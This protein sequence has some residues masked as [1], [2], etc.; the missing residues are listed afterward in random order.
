MF[1]NLQR[2]ERLDRKGERDLKRCFKKSG[3]QAKGSF[4]TKEAH[5]F[6][7]YTWE[8]TLAWQQEEK[9]QAGN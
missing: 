1:S 2:D 7:Q 9:G 4:Q 5:Q 6:Q 3:F 8:R